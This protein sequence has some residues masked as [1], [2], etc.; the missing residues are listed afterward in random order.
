[1]CFSFGDD[2]KLPTLRVDKLWECGGDL[3]EGFTAGCK[4]FMISHLSILSSS[5]GMELYFV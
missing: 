3:V 5:Y 1:M 4:T 2:L